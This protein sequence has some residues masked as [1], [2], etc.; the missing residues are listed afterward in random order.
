MLRAG[1]AAHR[2]MGPLAEADA[3]T[4]AEVELSY[5]FEPIA[6]S[7]SNRTGLVAAFGDTT[8][9]SVVLIATAAPPSRQVLVKLPAA[10]RC[11]CLAHMEW[12]PP[13]VEEML[14]LAFN[15][16]WVVV[17]SMTSTARCVNCTTF[18]RRQV[19][20]TAAYPRL[21]PAWP[22]ASGRALRLTGGTRGM[23]LQYTGVPGLRSASATTLLTTVLTL[24]LC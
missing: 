11:H 7:C 6:I 2:G 4:F 17:L 1:G 22:R 15:S 13:S 18:A 23:T 20:S 24:S 12:S 21:P 16:G 9:C 14:L 10:Q 3:R 5:P 19:V 8:A